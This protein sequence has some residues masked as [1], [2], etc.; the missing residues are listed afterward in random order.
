MSLKIAVCDDVAPEAEIVC[1]YARRFFSKKMTSPSIDTF[2]SVDEMMKSPTV[3]DL[4]LLDVMMTGLSG[5]EG[6]ALIRK[7][8]SAAVI[9]FITSSIDA[10]IDGY[11]VSASGFLLKPLSYDSFKDTMERIWKE[12]FSS[13]APSVTVTYNRVPVRLPLSGILYFENKL[14]YVHIHRFNA[15]TVIVHQKMSDLI[16]TLKEADGFI[17][18]HQSYIVN[19]NFVSDL[20]DTAFRMTNGDIVPISRAYYKETKT[21]YYRHCLR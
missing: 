12:K 18:C 10:A 6:A 14:H 19:L 17:R 11:R 13:A 20:L 3:Y 7:I 16:E 21:S 4:Y 1:G 8:S 15:D 2:S 5:I 9:V